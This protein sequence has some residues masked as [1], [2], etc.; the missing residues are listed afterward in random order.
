M[1]PLSFEKIDLPETDS[2][3]HTILS[4]Y[5][6]QWAL[7]NDSHHTKENGYLFARIKVDPKDHQC[8]FAQKP[9]KN[10]NLTDIK[11]HYHDLEG[12]LVQGQNC[13]RHDFE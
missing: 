7:I 6:E 9:D 13:I 4:Q 12:L 8:Y 11:M 10:G 3:K 1:F 2:A 5:Q